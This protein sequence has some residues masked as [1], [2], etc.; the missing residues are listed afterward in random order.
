MA[1]AIAF[2]NPFHLTLTSWNW[3]KKI[4]KW[5]LGRHCLHWIW[6]VTG[7]VMRN[8]TFLFPSP[9]TDCPQSVCYFL[10]SLHKSS[11]LIQQDAVFFFFM[12][13]SSGQLSD[14]VF[15]LA[16]NTPSS[17]VLKPFLLNSFFFYPSFF[18]KAL[19]SMYPPPSPFTVTNRR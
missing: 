1:M 12:L 14:D 8:T 4:K 17:F 3:A 13:S 18:Q 6:S 11:T 10:V 19:S 5:I 2:W 7:N 15:I 16:L 9:A